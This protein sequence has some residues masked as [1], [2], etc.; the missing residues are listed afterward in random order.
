MAATL[1]DV[2]RQAG[3]S[4]ATA[5]RVLND[6][7]VVPIA[8]DTVARIRATADSL[9]YRPHPL[10][11][12]LASGRSH[13]LGVYCANLVD[14]HFARMLKGAEARADSLGYHLIVS[15]NLATTAQR[16]R[17][18]G[19]ILLGAPDT[20]AF[21]ELP[22]DLPRVCVHNTP[23]VRPGL[24]GWNDADGM[25][26]AVRHLADLGHRRILA[27]F[28]Y[29][30][31]LTELPDGLAQRPKVDGLRAACADAGIE[32]VECWDAPEPDAMAG[33]NQIRNGCHAVERRIAQEVPF[34]AVVARNDF[35]ALGAL[36]ALR[37]A[38]IAVPEEVSVIGYT[39]SAQAAFADPPLT[40]VRTPIAEAGERAVEALAAL[41]DGGDDHGALLAPTLALRATD[42]PALR[43]YQ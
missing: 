5:S 41:L 2:A 14:P 39:D 6:K 4:K 24:I 34:T 25:A 8:G 20:P 28:C 37:A 1:Q 7:M 42:A 26:L 22:D 33:G 19:C 15:S 18:D 43:P 36:R 30:D 29:G 27:L 9:G 13:T 40:S 32:A 17:V 10:A 35:L 12:A 3:V 38:R 11:R 31:Q 21:A 16:G 23:E